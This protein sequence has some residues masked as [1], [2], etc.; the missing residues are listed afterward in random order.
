MPAY[1]DIYVTGMLEDFGGLTEVMFY[2]QSA[3]L[4][5]MVVVLAS[6]ILGLMNAGWQATWLTH[7]Q[8]KNTNLRHPSEPWAHM[9]KVNKEETLPCMFNS[10]TSHGKLR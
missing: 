4:L 10:P 3:I 9:Y 7:K 1:I 2:P 6:P 5:Q 8:L